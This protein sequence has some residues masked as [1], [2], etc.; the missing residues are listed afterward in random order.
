MAAFSGIL[1]AIGL[2]ISAFGA[3]TTYQAQKEA[4]A[5]Q[6][7]AYQLQKEAEEQRQRQMNLEAM[8]KKREIIRNSLAARSDALATT[9]A[10][11]AN[12]SGSSALPGAYGGISGQSGG[13]LLAVKQ[14]QEI[15]NEIFDIHGQMFDA[16]AA[17]ARAQGQAA[18]GQG[19]STLGGVLMKNNSTLGG[20]FGGFGAPAQPGVA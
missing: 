14:N 3:I 5:Q 7:K 18:F 6:E 15:G 20:F 8:R 9:T 12:G 10:Q 16:Y 19:L 4:A 11:G 17:G 13:Q 2:G 1:G